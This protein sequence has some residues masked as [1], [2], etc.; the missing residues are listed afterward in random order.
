MTETADHE[1]VWKYHSTYD[2]WWDGDSDDLYKCAVEGCNAREF[3][4]VGR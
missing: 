2:D 1:H 3:R 4:Y